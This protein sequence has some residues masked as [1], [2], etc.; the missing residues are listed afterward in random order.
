MLS[1]AQI[2]IMVGF[3]ILVIIALILGSMRGNVK[4]VFTEENAEVTLVEKYIFC[5]TTKFIISDSKS[6]IKI[7][8]DMEIFYYR[9]NNN[10]FYLL[11]KSF[12]KTEIRNRKLILIE[13]NKNLY[14]RYIIKEEKSNVVVK[15]IYDGSIIET[16]PKDLIKYVV[17]FM[18]VNE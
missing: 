16:V 6:K 17:I 12:P 1:L 13:Y 18:S 11:C 14:I 2:L 3:L 10:I 5:D 4:E 8:K 15:G 9:H 7:S